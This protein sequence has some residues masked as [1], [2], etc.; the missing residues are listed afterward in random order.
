MCV[1]KTMNE[2]FVYRQVS[3]L[4]NNTTH[5]FNI[6]GNTNNKF[7]KQFF[8]HVPQHM[9]M[10]ECEKLLNESTPMCLTFTSLFVCT[11]NCM[12]FLSIPTTC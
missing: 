1:Q 3:A 5:T 11:K 6:N 4:G 9:K 7:S 12:F 10:N 2:F 8:P